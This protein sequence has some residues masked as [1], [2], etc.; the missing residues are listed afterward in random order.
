[1]SFFSNLLKKSITIADPVGHYLRKA[2]GGSYGDPLNQYMSHPAGVAQSSYTGGTR[3]LQ[4]APGGVTQLGT[5][6]FAG[7]T[8][9]RTYAPNPFQGQQPQPQVQMPM[10]GVPQQMQQPQMQ[11]SIPGQMPRKLGQV[12]PQMLNGRA[13]LF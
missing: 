11:M 4:S 12:T 13:M 3:P 5:T 7:N 1:M 9:G 10:S 2:T 6:N 8:G